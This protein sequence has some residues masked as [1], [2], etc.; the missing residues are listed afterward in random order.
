LTNFKSNDFMALQLN[1]V[2][3]A[4]GLRWV[5]AALRLVMLRPMG[6]ILFLLLFMAATSLVGALLPYLGALLQMMAMPLLGLGFMIAARATRAGEPVHPAYLIQAL[7]PKTSTP[8][9]RK[10]LLQMFALYGVA[11]LLVM[12]LFAWLS[13]DSLS[14]I[15]EVM[16]AKLPAAE[17]QAKVVAIATEPGALFA[18]AFLMVLTTALSVPFWYAP[19][20]V[21]WGQ[22]GL[23][24]ALFSSTLAVW[25]S[26]GA[27]SMAMLLLCVLAI[28][29][30]VVAVLLA[31]LFGDP[32]AMGA[33]LIPSALIITTAFYVSVLFGYED[34]FGA[35]DAPAK[36]PATPPSFNPPA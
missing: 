18:A 34:S 7:R 27:W 16:A 24:Q 30:A 35:L 32:R 19:A 9:Q 28:G 26:K 21:Y 23:A 10:T 15:Q 1:H 36:P 13:G 12:L 2:P 22:Q 29:A 31:G 33:L 8:A 25:R 17:G 11:A 3:A 4:A 20:L 14:R 5:L 6:L